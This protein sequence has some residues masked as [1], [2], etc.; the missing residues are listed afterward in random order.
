MSAGILATEGNLSGMAV[1]V[2]AHPPQSGQG[3]QTALPLP[4]ARS[5][6]CRAATGLLKNLN[7]PINGATRPPT[8]EASPMIRSRPTQMI[9]RGVLL[10]LLISMA[11]CT[12]Q[13]VVP[14]ESTFFSTVGVESY[15]TYT[16]SGNGDL[17]PSCWADDGNLYAA[18][19]DGNNFG[20]TFYPMAIGQIAGM[21]PNLTGTF[22]TGDVGKNYSG[23]PYT[24]K[25]T[26]MVCV[27]GDIYLAYQNLNENTFEDAPAASIVESTDHGVTWSANPAMPMF[28]TPGNASD[29]TA[30]LFTTIVFLDFG[31]NYTNATDRYVYAYGLDNNWRDQTAVYLARVPA[32]SILDRSTWQFFAGMSG[33]TPAWSSDI[34]QKVA[35]LIDQAVLYQMLLSGSEYVAAACPADQVNIAQGGVTYDQP[36][37]RYIMVT[38]GCATQQFYEAPQPWGPWSHFYSKDYGPLQLPQ[39]VGQYGTSIPSKFI[40]ADGLTLDVQSNVCCSGN[41]YYTFSLRKLNVEKYSATSPVNGLSNTNLALAPGTFAIS[42]GTHYGLLCGLDCSDQIAN[43]P[44]DISEDD[45]DDQVKTVDWWGYT[46]PHAYNINQVT[47]T[48]GS[49]FPSGGWYQS[50]LTVQVRQNFQ[51]IDVGSV[52]ITPAYPYSSSAGSQQTYNLSFPATWGDGVRITGTPGGSAYFTS[53]T[54]LGIYYAANSLGSPGFNLSVVPGTISVGQGASATATVSVA[55]I[56]GFNQ[57]VSFA[58]SGLPSESSCSF[59]PKTVTPNG[60]NTITTTVSISTTAPSTASN[61]GRWPYL[62]SG[63]LLAFGVIFLSRKEQYS[64]WD[65]SGLLFVVAAWCVAFSGCGGSSPTQS[66]NPGT[67]TGTYTVIITA[68]SGLGTTTLTESATASLTVQ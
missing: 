9:S 5:D 47:Y 48:T 32:T 63:V 61:A 58:C 25:P 16:M 55:P 37:N 27:G 41:P 53:I 46:W 51:W 33:N 35:V 28:G 12:A 34:T 26:G 13:T 19:G 24:D 7:L 59:S 52:A 50:D 8:N 49:M 1:T 29:P 38:W 31:Q 62:G 10:I 23:S 40:S 11:K 42:R 66:T 30:Y 68:T 21:P 3:Q 15:S 67:P 36:L 18:N 54:Q 65:Y 60:L 45:W 39:N 57:Q 64:L 56:F 2:V 20:N 14:P 4:R 22:L 43:G 17:W 44:T 6:Y